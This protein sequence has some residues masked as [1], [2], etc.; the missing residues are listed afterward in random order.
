M[1]QDTSKD[2]KEEDRISSL[3]VGGDYSTNTNTFGRFDNF[4]KQPSFSPYI[5]YLSKYGFNIGA[6]GYFIG[7]SD[8]SGSQTT[9]ELDL[10]AGYDWQLIPVFSISPSYTHFFYSSNSS[11]LKKSYSDYVQLEANTTVNWWI[12]S[13]SG[14]YFWGEFS[15]LMLTAQ[16][17]ANITI[18][19]FLWRGNALVISPGAE[20]NFS[21]INYLRY[22]SDK[23]KFLKAYSTVY[24]NSTVN[25]LL[26]DLATSN[27]PLIRKLA[28]KLQSEAYLKKRLNTLD[29]NLVISTLF[30][31]K[32]EMKLSNIGF[33]LP[34]YYYVGRFTLNGTFAAYKPFNQPKIFGN[35]WVTYFSVGVSFTFGNQ[36][37][38]SF[39]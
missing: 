29:R 2:T 23:F 32:K 14:K 10:Q 7:N 18:N 30:D 21:D 35:D 31:D 26:N 4:A 36:G 33:T 20:I 8:P 22:I 6:V 13:I 9:S 12:S 25:D 19:D 3:I 1:A 39:K 16:T 15:E 5:S 38:N 34:L 17:S 24:P 11:I 27:R 37:Q 28:E